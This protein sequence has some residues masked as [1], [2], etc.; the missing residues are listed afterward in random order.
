MNTRFIESIKTLKK[1]ISKNEVIVKNKRWINGKEIVEIENIKFITQTLSSEE[2]EV[3]KAFT[4][5]LLPNTYYHFLTEIGSGQCFV[6]EY[7]SSFELYNFAELK[8]NNQLFQQEIKDYEK[9]VNEQFM[10]IGIH[11]SM[12]DWMGFCT[13]KTDEKNF[14]V[15]CHE[16]PIDEYIEISNEL[17]SWRSFEEWIIRVVETKGK[18][19]L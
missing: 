16:Y 14:D 13:S 4:N 17:N 18:E 6:G 15:Y 9:P 12:G 1:W 10:I 3:I 7:F 19:T 2:I 5:H 11:C 8:E